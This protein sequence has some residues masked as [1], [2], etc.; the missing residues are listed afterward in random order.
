MRTQ[1]AGKSPL[2]ALLFLLLS[3]SPA[4]SSDSVVD[5]CFPVCEGKE[6]GDDG[7]GGE[8]GTCPTAAP[9]CT[10]GICV[11]ECIPDCEGRE[12]GSDGCGGKCG[13]CQV[14]GSTCLEGQCTGGCEPDCDGKDCGD[15]G[16]GGSCGKCEA[17]DEECVNDLCVTTCEPDCTDAVCGDDGCGGNCGPC[18]AGSMCVDGNCE[19]APKCDG[20]ECGADG[21]G[22]KCGECP[23]AAPVCEAGKC[24]AEC[25]PDCEGKECGDD[26]CDGECGECSDDASCEDGVC[27]PGCEP[28]CGMSACGDD[29]CGGSCGDCPDDTPICDD[30]ECVADCTPDCTDKECGEDGCGG[31]CGK[32]PAM[33]PIC[34]N[35]KCIADC[36]PDCVGKEC[37]DDGCG[38]VCGTCPEVA[39]SC[40]DSKCVIPCEPAC[41]GK[42][43]GPDGCGGICGICPAGYQ[44][45]GGNCACIPSCAGKSCGADGCGG[46]CGQC[47]QGDQCVDSNCVCVAQCDGKSCGEDGCGSSCGTCQQGWFCTS[48]S[49][50]PPPALDC[51]GTDGPAVPGCA[52]VDTYE[53]CCSALKL[54][55]CEDGNTYCIDCAED[56]CGWQ[57]AGDYYDCNTDG[58]NDPSGAFIKECEGG[59]G[60]IPACA[61]KQC[62]DDG[63]GGSCGICGNEWDMCD[64][65]TCEAPCGSLDGVWSWYYLS[66]YNGLCWGDELEIAAGKSTVQVSEEDGEYV[67]ASLDLDPGQPDVMSYYSCYFDPDDCKLHC[68]CDTACLID[69]YAD[70]EDYIGESLPTPSGN[71]AFEL[72]FNGDNT[73]TYELWQAVYAGGESCVLTSDSYTPGEGSQCSDCQETADCGPYLLCMFYTYFPG[74]SY[75]TAQCD[76]DSDCPA[77]FDCMDNGTCWTPQDL[78]PVCVEGD[79][80]FLDACDNTIGPWELCLADEICGTNALCKSAPEGQV[81]SPC[82]TINDC[83]AGDAPL[84][85]TEA[86]NEFPGGYCTSFCNS[87]GAGACPTGAGCFTIVNQGYSLC[88]DNCASTNDCRGSY[89][90]DQ[91]WTCYP[92]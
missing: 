19:C 83:D 29:G 70:Y 76:E 62:G 41:F 30:G 87:Q 38:G 68:A 55:W 21:C 12:C 10:E 86:D 44:C 80:W 1:R 47:D 9:D 2:M 71:V 82:S 79:T 88:F 17:P 25:D 58:G 4:C 28:H 20:K 14:D 65:G 64:S 46:S 85:L 84:C 92:E 36:A 74:N 3:A 81:G 26:G 67:L 45:S 51:Q 72:Q 15:D 37:G 6:C 24:V 48:G 42:N 57:P 54:V 13:S 89:Y 53:G 33:A 61:G 56:T 50:S 69:Y 78:D 43:C 63:C 39:P 60:C 31:A 8:C 66:D 59:S 73:V 40:E 35:F 18:G 23:D 7:C 91:D 75:C 32:C 52:Y 22:G 5:Q 90:C 27:V 11:A 49:C 16:C 77:G 34:E